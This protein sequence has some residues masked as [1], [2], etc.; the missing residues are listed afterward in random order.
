[1]RGR[2]GGGGLLWL[3]RDG[4]GNKCDEGNSYWFLMVDYN[5]ANDSTIDTSH[6]FPDCNTPLSPPSAHPLRLSLV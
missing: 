3:R 4:M 2:K 1:M 5:N 6:I